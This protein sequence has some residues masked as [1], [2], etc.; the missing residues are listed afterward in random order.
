MMRIGGF[1]Y[2]NSKVL[3]ELNLKTGELI[4][5]NSEK[6]KVITEFNCY[7]AIVMDSDAA[8]NAKVGDNVKIQISSDQIITSEIVH[9]NEENERRVIVFKVNDLPEK[10]INYRKISVDVIWWEDSGLKVPNSALI[11][12]GDKMYI[13]KN[14]AN[15]K[16]RV[17]VKVLR[18]NDAYAIVDNYTAQE[19]QEM[20]YSFDEIQNMYSIKQYDKIDVKN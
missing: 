5:T 9:I 12:D 4:E 15:Y 13:E 19:L 14:R 1:N 17:L 20:G 3:D 16:V 6:G 10:M 8:M 2:I 7:L 18:Q 11:K